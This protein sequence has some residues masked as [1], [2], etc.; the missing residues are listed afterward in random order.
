KTVHDEEL[1]RRVE[2]VKR[3]LGGEREKMENVRKTVDDETTVRKLEQTLQRQAEIEQRMKQVQNQMIEEE[4]IVVEKKKALETAHSEVARTIEEVQ[5]W[6]EETMETVRLWES[7][8]EERKEEERKEIQK[9]CEEIKCDLIQQNDKIDKIKGSIQDEVTSSRVLET[10]L[11]QREIHERIDGVK[12]KMSEERVV[13]DEKKMDENRAERTVEEIEMWQEEISTILRL[14]EDYRMERSDSEKKEIEQ[15]IEAIRMDSAV[16]SERIETT[17]KNVKEQEWS[18]RISSI[19]G[20]Q[21]EIGERLERIQRGMREKSEEMKKIK[22]EQQHK[23]KSTLEEVEMWQE[24]SVEIIRLWTEKKIEEKKVQMEEVKGK[25][26]Q[27]NQI[28]QKTVQLVDN[29]ETAKRMEK[30][31]VKQHEIA[32]QLKKVKEEQQKQL[33]ST[34]EEVEMWQDE[35]VEIIRLWSEKKKEVKR[36]QIEEVKGKMEQIDQRLRQTIRL[37]EDEETARKMERITVRQNQIAA[38]LQKMEQQLKKEE[39]T[40]GVEEVKEIIE[41]PKITTQLIDISI[42]EGKRIEFVA[43]I[44]SKPEATI[45][46]LKD[47][48]NVEQSMDY[49]K[50]YLNGVATLTIEETFIEDSALYTCRAKNEGGEAESSGRLVVTSVRHPSAPPRV[51]RGLKSTSIEEGDSLFLDCVVVAEPEPQVVWFKEE[52]TIKED[53]RTRLD[54][55]GD[56]CSLTVQPTTVADSGMYTAKAKNVHGE[57]TSLCQVKV[58]PKKI[59]PPTPPKPDRAE[60]RVGVS[61]PPA[62]QCTLTNETY[63]EGMKAVLQVMVTGTPRPAIK[64]YINDLPVNTERVKVTIEEDGWT[65]LIIDEIREDDAGLYMVVAENDIGEARTGATIHVQPKMTM[66]QVKR[67]FEEAW[68]SEAVQT[69]IDVVPPPSHRSM[70]EQITVEEN[71]VETTQRMPPTQSTTI[72]METKT[73]GREEFNQKDEEII[74]VH[75]IQRDEINTTTTTVTTTSTSH[76]P[77]PTTTRVQREEIVQGEIGLS[78]TSTAPDV[79]RPLQKEYTFN[80]D[81][82]LFLEVLLVAN[83]RPKVQWFFNDNLIPHTSQFAEISASGD[84]Y[85]LRV[86]KARLENAGYYRIRVENV[87]GEKESLCIVHIRPAALG[88]APKTKQH[89]TVQEEFAMFE[90]E[91]RRPEFMYESRIPTLKTSQVNGINV[92]TNGVVENK[93]VAE[94]LEGYDLTEKQRVGNPPHFTQ[95]L[96]STVTADGSGAKFEGIVTGWPAPEMEWVKDGVVLTRNTHPN[97]TVSNI[98]GRVSLNFAHCSVNDSGKYKCTASNE[99]GVATSSAQLV[100][101]PKTVAPDFI[102][103]LISE[104]IG[105]GDTLKWT[106]RVSGDPL[107]SV[108]WLRDGI[109]IPNCDEVKIIDEGSG[110]HSMIIHR[111]EMADSGQF[112]CLAENSAGEAR[113]TADLVVRPEGTEPGHYFHVTKVTQEKQIKGQPVIGGRNEAFTIESPMV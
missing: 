20:K 47:G 78:N 49:R 22:M 56:H 1:N 63:Q 70:N 65:R 106:V 93:K 19:E 77:V 17:K 69:V 29:E 92:Q 100:V 97:I 33:R 88:P 14:W 95:T 111:V 99:W 26:E 32:A 38:Q 54:F 18:S 40:L 35:I 109:I 91:Q 81:S 25:M 2:E 48:V 71:R 89:V 75:P 64:W 98:G 39:E 41:K 13:A 50:T 52:S 43:K 55:K 113:S 103:R 9:K 45:M 104:E 15:S 6:Q 21:K 11:R 30:I 23:L 12:R 94:Y 10:V 86:K 87:R 82:E 83:P 4:R 101:R 80:E 58:A 61:R 102:S 110:V 66:T 60:S 108:V 74:E 24:E 37:I 34:L 51:V 5:M 57:A 72:V 67:S 62:M 107:P 73:R 8:R 85:S 3:R 46:W 42:E 53:E 16:Q 59:P 68:G 112:T 27:V 105:E 7:P 90:Y 36:V 84:S 79:I 31:T 28:L 76:I 44:Q 96:L